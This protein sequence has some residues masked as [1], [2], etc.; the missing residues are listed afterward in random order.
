ML[1]QAD[2]PTTPDDETRPG[3]LTLFLR[4]DFE[5]SSPQAGGIL[6]IIYDDGFVVYVNGVEV[7]RANMPAG[8]VSELTPAT[9]AIEPGNPIEIVVP[10]GALRAGTNVLAASVHNASL[11]SSDL[12]FIPVLAFPSG[13][14][15][16]RF[17]RG[18]I[19][20]DGGTNITDAVFL[21]DHLFR[22][23]P[24]PECPDAAD[25]NDDGGWHITDPLL[26]N[27]LFQGLGDPPLPGLDCGPDPTEDALG[28]CATTGC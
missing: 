18:D 5:L 26:L 24:A 2:D 9:V 16:A 22:S 1:M 19:T 13:G 11:T 28:N 15:G 25:V 6:S 21:L 17:R 27:I 7:G 23:G 14:G 3:Y 4:K 8:P 20:N 12:S 10:A